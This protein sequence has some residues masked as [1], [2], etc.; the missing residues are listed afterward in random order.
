MLWWNI[1]SYLLGW[2]LF[3]KQKIR[4]IGKVME[5]LEPLYTTIGNATAIDN[6]IEIPQI[7]KL[8][9]YPAIPLLDISK[10]IEITILK[11]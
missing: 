2:L 11:R 1:T 8:P 9:Y 3:K 7:L 4:S 6:S 10:I 5:K